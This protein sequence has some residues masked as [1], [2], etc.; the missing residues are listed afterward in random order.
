M[1]RETLK[2]VRSN[3]FAVDDEEYISGVRCVAA[4]IF[5]VL[6]HPVAVI[7]ISGPAN[8]IALAKCNEYGHLVLQFAND[9]SKILGSSRNVN[10]HVTVK[11]P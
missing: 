8:R 5:N 10:N 1:L 7:G 11:M 9:I 6:N 4:P 3:G 2:E